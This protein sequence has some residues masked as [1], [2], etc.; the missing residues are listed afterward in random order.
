MPSH[1]LPSA[2][3]TKPTNLPYPS[4]GPLFKGRED[5]INTIRGGFTVNPERAQAISARQA[6]HGLGGIGKTRAAVEYA[7]RFAA[8]Y[9]ALF[10]VSAAT[11][12]DFRANVAALCP[13]LR[14]ADGVTNDTLRFQA[15]IEWLRNLDNRG[16]LLIVDNLDTPEAAAEAE[17]SVVTL[18]A[19]HILITG[20]L[21][22]WPV[23]I[24]S[25]RLD[26]LEREAAT[27][28]LLARTADK[29]QPR[30]DD[31]AEADALAGELDGLALALE[32]AAAFLRRRPLSFSEYLRRWRAAD[33][34]VRRWHDARTM[35]Y[36]R[37]LA[38][39]WQTT[40][41][42]TS[43]CRKVAALFALVA[44]PGSS[45]PLPV[46]SRCRSEWATAVIR[47]PKDAS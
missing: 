20:R 26:V 39:T 10:F 36:E 24:E 33:Q 47:W 12:L 16:W 30:E 21:S 3:T 41:R 35:Q 19:G 4:L 27:E 18:D 43:A 1:P 25:R 37:P 8:D 23:F 38:A 28:F 15:A 6:I 2:S 34:R 46:R 5:F 14:V 45:P 44:R 42:Y 31:A 11:P 22:E 40:N 32:Q 17:K 13:I 29:R 9:T 7:W